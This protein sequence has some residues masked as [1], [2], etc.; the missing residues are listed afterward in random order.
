[1]QDIQNAHKALT[2]TS[3]APHGITLVT[4]VT[5]HPELQVPERVRSEQVNALNF[6]HAPAAPDSD[7][8]YGELGVTQTLTFGGDPYA[9]F[10]PWEAVLAI[11]NE[12]AGIQA[13]YKVVDT[14]TD[15]KPKRPALK[16][17]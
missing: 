10:I 1:M 17:V 16:L 11:S 4:F 7:L 13:M 15:A 14:W 9:C 3:V 8:T 6:A 2:F 12:A 5:N